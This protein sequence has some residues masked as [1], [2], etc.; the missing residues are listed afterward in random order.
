MPGMSGRTLLDPVEVPKALEPLVNALRERPE[1]V[2]AYWY[3]S[4]AEAGLAAAGADV[5]VAVYL[6]EELIPAERQFEHVMGLWEELSRTL[7]AE[8]DL[9]ALNGKPPGFRYAASSGRLLMVRDEERLASYLER[10]W[11]EWFDFAPVAEKHL[12]E[13][14]E[15]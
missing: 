3:G 9:H 14:A 8:L 1:I 5:D 7:R 10:T 2:F 11:D 15:S 6:D 13:L 4:T 12:R